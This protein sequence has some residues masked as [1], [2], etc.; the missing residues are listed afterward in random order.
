MT[1]LPIS[2]FVETSL[3]IQKI[4]SLLN[5][6]KLYHFQFKVNDKMKSALRHVLKRSANEKAFGFI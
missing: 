6:R 4:D 2:A 5:K 3:K 1:K